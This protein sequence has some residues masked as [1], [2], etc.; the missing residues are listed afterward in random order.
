MPSWSYSLK[1]HMRIQKDLEML[2]AFKEELLVGYAFFLPKMGRITQ[3]AVHPD[4]RRQ[5]IGTQ[6]FAEISRLNHL[7]MT[8]INVDKRD[9]ATLAFL[10]K[11]GFSS[12]IGQ[13]EMRMII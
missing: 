6:L 5:K 4:Y 1:A 2:G 7:K 11:I 10:Q 8:V 13:F 12:Y 9:I 3:F